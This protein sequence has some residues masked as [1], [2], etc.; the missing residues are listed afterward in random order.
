MRYQPARPLSRVTLRE[1]K[2]DDDS[3]GDSSSAVCLGNLD[4]VLEAYDSRLAQSLNDPFFSTPLSTLFEQMPFRATPVPGATSE[5][6]E[7]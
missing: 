1:F 2:R 5:Q 7:P 4:P 3:L 6:A